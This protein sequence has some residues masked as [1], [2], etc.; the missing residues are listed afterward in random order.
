MLPAAPAMLESATPALA[1]MA[2]SM[3]NP[4]SVTSS[5]AT[6]GP[7]NKKLDEHFDPVN[8]HLPAKSCAR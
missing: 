7:G 1:S 6:P 5:P 3:S 4:G 8:H 2:A